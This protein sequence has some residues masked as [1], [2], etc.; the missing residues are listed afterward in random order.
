MLREIYQRCGGNSERLPR[1][2]DQYLCVLAR[3]QGPFRYVDEVLARYEF[4]LDA[5]K[6]ESWLR[7]AHTYEQMVAERFGVRGTGSGSM[8]CIGL[9]CMARGDRVRA[10]ECFREAIRL[11]PLTLK[12]WIRLAWAYAPDRIMRALRPVMPAGIQR[13]L[14]GPPRG[15]WECVTP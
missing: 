15:L 10:R 4:V 11:R 6:A 9:V 1:V 14:D 3:E 2:H 12:T 7:D 13:S 5:A 8:V